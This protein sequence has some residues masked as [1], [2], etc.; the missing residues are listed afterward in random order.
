MRPSF[1]RSAAISLGVRADRSSGAAMAQGHVQEL[2][3]AMEV[4]WR[5]QVTH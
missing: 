5:G 3:D 2:E 4:N 1:R